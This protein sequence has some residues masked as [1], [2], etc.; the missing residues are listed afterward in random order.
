M[1]TYELAKQ[2]GLAGISFVAGTISGYILRGLIDKKNSVDKLEY[3]NLVLLVVTLVWALS[4][5]I[6]IV[7]PEYSTSPLIHGLMGGIVGF[8]F[9][10]KN[11]NE[12]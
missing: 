2:V 9:K 6:D 7:D 10:K 3:R 5:L 8:F 4:A 11:K 12:K 1:V